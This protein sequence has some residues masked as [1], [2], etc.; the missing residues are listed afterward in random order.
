M[1]LMYLNKF[2]SQAFFDKKKYGNMNFCRLKM[3]LTASIRVVINNSYFYNI[4]YSRW[5]FLYFCLKK[6]INKFGQKTEYS[7]TECK[8]SGDCWVIDKLIKQTDRRLSDSIHERTQQWLHSWKK[9]GLHGSTTVKWRFWSIYLRIFC[10][11]R[12]FLLVKKLRILTRA[13]K[14][15]K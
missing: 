3:D 1:L 4:S 11:L 10:F 8:T 5:F 7:G 9:G 14:S 15:F 2:K 6:Y 12:I 13:R